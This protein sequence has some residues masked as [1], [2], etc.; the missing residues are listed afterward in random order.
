MI[1]IFGWVAFSV[2]VGI[3]AMLRGRH[4]LGWI[5]LSILVSP[6]IALLALMALRRENKTSDEPPL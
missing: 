3:I 6:L 4:G 2:L 5:T 1:F